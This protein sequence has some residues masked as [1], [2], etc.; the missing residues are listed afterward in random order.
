M[1]RPFLPL[2]GAG[3]LLAASCS[4]Q[5]AANSPVSALATT[6][7][8]VIGGSLGVAYQAVTGS[9]PAQERHL[10]HTAVYALPD[11]TVAIA[12]HSGWFTDHRE[13]AQAGQASQSAWVIDLKHAA[14][15]VDGTILLTDKNLVRWFFRDHPRAKLR[16][17]PAEDPRAEISVTTGDRFRMDATHQS[18]TLLL[19]SDT[20]RFKLTQDKVDAPDS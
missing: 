20:Y 5:N 7:A 9:T 14:R 1:A 4:S 17:I 10:A 3:L 15:G 16:L 18:F 13:F 12:N 11:G 8:V 2:L 19:G 6:S